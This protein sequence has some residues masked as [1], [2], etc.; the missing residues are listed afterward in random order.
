MLQEPNAMSA[1]FFSLTVK[2]GMCEQPWYC[3]CSH[4]RHLKSGRMNPSSRITSRQHI[5]ITHI[6]PQSHHQSLFDSKTKTRVFHV[7]YLFK[8]MVVMAESITQPTNF[9]LSCIFLP[10]VSQ[11]QGQ[12]KIN[13]LQ[14]PATKPSVFEATAFVFPLSDKNSTF[15]QKAQT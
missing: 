15:A 1:S 12:E 10:T 7:F 8:A 3:Q 13:T 9:T 14:L 4:G 2:R 5:H 6:I 11:G